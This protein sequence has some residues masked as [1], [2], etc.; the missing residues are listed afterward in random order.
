MSP[1]IQVSEQSLYLLVPVRKKVIMCK[2]NILWMLLLFVAMTLSAQGDRPLVFTVSQTQKNCFRTINEAIQA[3]PEHAL[4]PVIIY[5]KNGI[6]RE[7]ILIDRPHI[8]LV[9]ENRDSTRII[10]A[11][12]NKKQSTKEMFGKPLGPGIIYLNEEGNDC[13]IA[14]LTAYNNYGTTVERTIQHQM[15][16]FSRATRVKIFDCTIMSDGHDDVS[17]WDT[18]G[19]YYYHA[20]C[21]FQSPGYD[22]VC[23][24]GW[25]YM[26]RCTVYGKGSGGAMIWHD[27]RYGED[28]K[29]V[30]RDCYFDSSVPV[31]L[32]RYHHD[33]QFFLINCSCSHKI[34]DR[35]IS[36]AYSYQMLDSIALGNR[37]YFYNFKR[38]GGNFKW[39]K[40]NLEESKQKPSP[41]EITA[42][43]TFQGKWDPEVEA[44]R[45]KAYMKNLK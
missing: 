7:K 17:M 37:V 9:G 16:V 14:R 34:I 41:D 28:V 45:L 33:S 27:G 23:P 31:I 21:Y 11:E 24:R 18:D 40:N 19:G 4:Q 15:T 3:A 29:F 22:F 13:T 5:I 25:C 26:T 6:Y 44:S 42:K 43:W 1:D 39:M 20:D 8:C 30:M 12:L 35:P 32:G 38:E 36:S 10:L 2:K